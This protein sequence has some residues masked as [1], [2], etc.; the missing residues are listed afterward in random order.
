M[1]R[2]DFWTLWEKVRVGCFERT[3][4]ILSIVKQITSPGGMHETS[5]WAWCTGKT[6]RNRVER[7]VGGGSGW[8][9]HVTLWLIHV[10]VWQNPRKCC[11]VI[12][13]Q[14]IKI[15]EN[16]IKKKEEVVIIHWRTIQKTLND[17]C[18]HDDVVIHLEPDILECEVKRALISNTKNKAGGGDRILAELFQ[19]LKDDVKVVHSMCQQIWK[20]QQWPQD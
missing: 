3:A 20:T 15:N 17:L 19:I 13:L 12:S 16:K 10:N 6:Q 9:I 2:T 5:A 18:N 11:E 14:L 7:K 8:G 4:C 1:Y